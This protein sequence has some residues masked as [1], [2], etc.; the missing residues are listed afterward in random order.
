MYTFVYTKSMTS[1]TARIAVTIV[2]FLTTTAAFAILV[3]ALFVGAMGPGG[4]D[5]PHGEPYDHSG[6]AT[7]D[8]TEFPHCVNPADFKGWMPATSVIVTDRGVAREVPFGSAWDRNHDATT[9][10]DVRVI[11]SCA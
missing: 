4:V 8:R 2:R 10:N 7:L 1:R 6:P 5:L 3:G 9:I 11:G